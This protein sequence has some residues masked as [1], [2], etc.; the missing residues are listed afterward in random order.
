MVVGGEVVFRWAVETVF[1][2]GLDRCRCSG[3]HGSGETHED[4]PV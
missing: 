3:E 1:S 2:Q 4:V